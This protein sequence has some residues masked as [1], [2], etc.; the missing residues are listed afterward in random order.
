MSE[1]YESIAKDEIPVQRGYFLSEEDRHFRHYIL[2]ISCKGR[3][4]FN[5]IDL[6]AL[7]QFSFPELK[8]LEADGL[9]TWNERS[10]TVTTLGRQFIRNICRAFDLHL[11]RNQQVS[12]LPVFSKAI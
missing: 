9:V 3:T 10:L 5:E 1:Y 12:E 2:D 6:P 8:Q 11:L 4:V 7:K